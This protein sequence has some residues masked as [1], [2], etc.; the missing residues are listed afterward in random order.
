MP[1]VSSCLAP[2]QWDLLPGGGGWLLPVPAGPQPSLA[3]WP[4]LLVTPFCQ[5]CSCQRMGGFA[6]AA[7]TQGWL[8]TRGSHGCQ[9]SAW[10]HLLSP[11]IVCQ[12]PG[13]HQDLWLCCT[14]QRKEMETWHSM[15][16]C[17]PASL[18]HLWLVWLRKIPGFWQWGRHRKATRAW[19][20]LTRSRDFHPGRTH[21]RQHV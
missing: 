15:A 20:P 9:C 5:M 3:A 7:R 4:P 11:G 12:A 2:S 17:S 1:G 13:S 16:P 18:L 8:L 10:L 14:S 19:V 6:V 21:S